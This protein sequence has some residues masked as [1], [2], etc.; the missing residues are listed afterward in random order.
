VR[1]A[2]NGNVFEEHSDS[3]KWPAGDGMGPKPVILP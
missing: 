3:M 1:K 2:G